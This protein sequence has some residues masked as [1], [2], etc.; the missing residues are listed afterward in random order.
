MM[1]YD[2]SVA[3]AYRPPRHNIKKEN[4]DDFF[5]TR[6]SK[7]IADGDY[8]CKK[9]LWDSQLTTTKDR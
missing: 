4:I 3:S 8:N 9:T 6:E 7:I 5:K 2:L 1:D